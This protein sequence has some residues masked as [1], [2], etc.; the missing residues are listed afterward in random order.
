MP[1]RHHLVTAVLVLPVASLGACTS[2]TPAAP[3]RTSVGP[4]AGTST[5]TQA[6]STPTS[7]MTSIGGS[8]EATSTPVTAL[9]KRAKA[10]LTKALL[11]LDDLP[12]G[13]SVEPQD[14]KDSGAPNI[15]SNNP[16]C[17]PLVAIM[18]ADSAPG[19]VASATTSFSGGQDGPWI[20]EYLDAM[21]SPAKVMAFHDELRKAVKACSKVTMRLPEGRSTMAVRLVRAPDASKDAVAFRV[22]AQGGAL[23]G[24]EATQVASAVDDV[25]LSMIFLGAYPEEIDEGTHAAYEKAAQELGA[26][27]VRSS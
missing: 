24:F 19:S 9:P 17:R 3:A 11:V 14:G 22:T 21:G 13:F 4:G 5:G 20:D 6:P 18:N 12:A 7:S 2:G 26:K 23:D 10:S 8:G 25:D 15:S 27:D 1:R 16:S